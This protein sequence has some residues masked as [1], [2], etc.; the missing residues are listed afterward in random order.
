MRA[1]RRIPFTVIFNKLQSM[2]IYK[3]KIKAYM[4]CSFNKNKIIIYG[5]NKNLLQNMY[6]IIFD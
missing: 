5:L 1:L 6:C 2:P 3:E 4:H